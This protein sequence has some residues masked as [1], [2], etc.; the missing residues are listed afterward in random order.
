MSNTETKWKQSKQWSDQFLPEIKR[1]LG[2]HLIREGT[3]EE[4][5]K[6]NTDLIVLT[7]NPIRIACRIRKHQHLNKGNRANEFTIRKN[8]PSG[9]PSEMRKI[10]NGWGDYFFYGFSNET[11]TAIQK[12]FIGDLEIFRNFVKQRYNETKKIPATTMINTDGS[13]DF[14]VF[15]LA[16]MPDN[17]LLADS[18]IYIP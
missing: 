6:Q 17:F 4:D 12:W 3:I 1:I 10:W 9:N 16:D 7:L 14:Y 15:K 5:T 8:V 11:E 18:N 13:S 2:E